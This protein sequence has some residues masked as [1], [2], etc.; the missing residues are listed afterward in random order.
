MFTS[1]P[2][3]QK[4]DARP[5]SFLLDDQATGGAPA[6]VDLVIRPEDLTRNDPSR[7][8]VQQTLGGAWADNFGPGVPT[9]QISGH[10]GWRPT[11]G[12]GDGA[13][14]FQ[15]LY[16]QVYV[17]WHE[18]R[19]AAVQAGMDPDRVKLVFADALDNFTVV[20]APMSFTLRRS[21]SRPLLSQYQINMTVLGDDVGAGGLFGAL[22]GLLNADVLEAAGLD[23]LTASI[24]EITSAINNVHQWV[25]RTIVAPVRTFMQQTARLYGAVR[26]AISAADGIAGSLI[27]VARMTAQA[28]I[29]IFRTAAAIANIPSQVR[30]RLMQVAGAYTNIFCVLRN[31]LNQQ[32]YY[33]DYSP[34]FGAS[35]CSSTSGGRPISVLAGQNPFYSVVPTSGPLPVTLTESAQSSLRT[36]AANDP[37]LARMSPVALY[38]AVRSVADG[39]AVAV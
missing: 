18:R 28:G 27:S 29:N 37:V 26:G 11:F 1:A 14:R 21:R 32:I 4:A 22:G 31:A 9:I 35:N 10:T 24:N 23:S 13:A 7:L 17:Q 3:S 20:V 39:M 38:S 8:N 6:S 2:S 5:I 12:S 34:L 30:A 25:D 15:Q 19:A 36:L 33:E 16:D